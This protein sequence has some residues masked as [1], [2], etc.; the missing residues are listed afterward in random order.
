MRCISYQG[1]VN[2]IARK[3][4]KGYE[5]LILGFDFRILLQLG[6]ET[7]TV[8]AWVSSRQ[9]IEDSSTMVNCRCDE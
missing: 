1:K 6:F 8:S 4:I 7:G 5:L 9:Y 2:L 3:I